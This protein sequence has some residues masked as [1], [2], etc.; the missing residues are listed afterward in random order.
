[1]TH[2]TYKYE[3]AMREALEYFGG[4]DLP[5][6][7]FVDKYAMRNNEGNFVE[8]TPDHMH[9]RLASEFARIDSEKYGLD[10]DERY[11][12]YRE[13]V[14]RFGRIVPQGSPMAAIGNKHQKMSASNCVVVASPKDS[15]E[16]IMKSGTDL[17]QLMKRR[18]VEENTLIYTR[19]KGVV[20]IKDIEIGMHVLSFDTH[21]KASKYKRVKDKFKSD[22]L[23]EDRIELVFSN[24]ARLKTSK[25]H[26]VLLFENNEYRYKKAG[27]IVEGDVGVKP[28]GDRE[29]W[30][31]NGELS[32]VAW[33]IGAHMGDG[34]IDQ[35][36]VGT[37]KDYGKGRYEYPRLRFRFLGDNEVLVAKYARVFNDL[38][39]SKANYAISSR[40]DYNT[41]CW[42]YVNANANNYSIADKYF[43]NQVGKKTYSKFTPAF[44]KENG[45]WWSY[46]GG[47]IDADGHVKNDGEA[48]SLRLCAPA[49]IDDL[50]VFLSAL[51]ISCK[52]SIIPPRRENEATQYELY[53]H[54]NAELWNFLTPY[55][56]HPAKKQK[57]L[58]KKVREFS[59]GKPISQQE[60][61]EIENAYV[62]SAAPK[63]GNLSA[64]MKLLRARSNKTM[65]VGGLNEFVKH[66]II[67]PAKKEEISQRVFVNEVLED[68][69]SEVYYDIEVEDTNNFY[70]GN[71]GLVNIHNCGV[72][73]DISTL[74]PEGTSVNNAARTT[75]GA[76]SFADFFSYV[77]RMIGQSGR[78]GALMVTIDVHHPDV[79]QFA[80]MKQDLTKVTGA[81][82]SVR[83][84]DEFLKAVDED[85]EY[86]QRWPCEGEEPKVR[87][88]VRA[89]EVWDVIVESATNTAEPGLI[90]WDNMVNNL[91]AHAYP[92]F[93]TVSTNPCSE[94]ALSAYD[95]CRLI[96]INLTGYVRNAF[97]DDSHFDWDA[98]KEDVRTAMQ[99]ADNLVDLELGL[100]NDIMEICSTDTE[101]A[102][103][104]KL[105]DAGFKGRRT[106]LGTHGLGDTLAQLCL[107]YDG[108]EALQWVDKL[109]ST[110]R[111]EAYSASIELA[112]ARG[113]FPAFDWELEKSN[114]YIKRLPKKIRDGLAAHGRRNIAMLTQAPTGSVSI[115]SKC[116][117][118]QA[119]NVSS[120]VEP[121]FRNS[122]TRRKKIQHGDEG[123][124]VDFVDAL[125]DKWQEFKV[126]HPNVEHY[127][128]LHGKDP[129]QDHDL[130]D[131]FVTSDEIDWE[132]RV[133]IQGV[134]QQYI[135]HSISSTINLPRG[136]G[137]DVV[138]NLYIESWK[139]G[140]KGVTVYVDGSRDG[141]LITETE[142][143]DEQGRPTK[144]NQVQ[145]PKRPDELPCEI[146]HATVKGTPWTVLLGML[147]ETPYEIFMGYSENISL[148]KKC[149]VGKVIKLSKGRYELHVDIG[150]DEPLVVKDIIKTFDNPESAWA[151][152]MVSLSLRHGVPL[153]FVVEQ[154]NKDGGVLDVNKVLSRILKKFIRDGAKVKSNLKCPQCGSE[155]FI[156]EEGCPRC[157]DCGYTKCQ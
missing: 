58:N 1:M 22:V 55:L 53:I 89:R 15:I 137:T 151:T 126:Y 95:S 49:I 14:D 76:W 107:R 153:E 92:E 103:W 120:G 12:V 2:K 54:G 133:E 36:T 139:K 6:R 19:E 129:T 13:A 23:P 138:G 143:K 16:G 29:P 38:S 43:D 81:N 147:D 115:I 141:V 82:V 77:T 150:G 128:K 46:L 152:R 24:G 72:G 48:I 21:S 52:T 112:K 59:H 20:P 50:A 142:N 17:A 106:G 30:L 87:R 110:L 4:S 111:N 57:L 96:S 105:W 130:P 18:C 26:P 42:E 33:F 156:Y 94:I 32:D 91:P 45:L 86:E 80:T 62:E 10:Y 78:R 144:I 146:H 34:S 56:S 118:F 100:I 39:G 7:V 157:M 8:T 113:P 63:I 83:L 109:Y 69:E 136:T 148:P 98:F 90:M 64:C 117:E 28:E 149:Q 41:T 65:G 134:E 61:S 121:V 31:D 135:D 66:K 108:P 104:Q 40:A 97:G 71:F 70:A 123:A 84:S 44:I 122:Y 11:A 125:G 47:L 74:R 27:Y 145:S 5:A 119:H 25:K 51:G 60:L 101:R 88:K 73:I 93:Y 37:N 3:E 68:L 99:M 67:T 127:L 140:L 116:G 102:L 124:R 131:Y 9:D 154:L 155:N 132:Q 114:A 85:T 75:S 79:M 35:V